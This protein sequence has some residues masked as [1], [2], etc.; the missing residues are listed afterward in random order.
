[1]ECANLY[2]P[3]V[4]LAAD[5]TLSSLRSPVE[6]ARRVAEAGFDPAKV[7]FCAGLPVVWRGT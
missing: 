4:L 6:G 1:M 3:H 7:S 5:R 2:D